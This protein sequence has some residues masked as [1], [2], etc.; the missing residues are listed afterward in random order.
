[1]DME[2]EQI[3]EK[4]ALRNV[5]LVTSR[6]LEEADKGLATA[7]TNRSRIEYYFTAKASLVLHVLD[8]SPEANRVTYLDA[9]LFFFADPGLL[10]AELAG[11]SVAIS[12]HRF[13]TKNQHLEE[14]GL[15]NAGWLM[16]RRDQDGMA[17]L[18]WWR[19]KCL[20]WCRDVVDGDRYADQKYIDRFSSMFRNVCA[21]KHAGANLAPW[22]L[23][24]AALE[25][26]GNM[27]QANGQ[28]LVFFHFHG[29]KRIVPGIFDAGTRRYGAKLSR[30]ARF[31]VYRSYLRSVNQ[32]ERLVGTG[33]NPGM[34]AGIRNEPSG[35]AGKFTSRLHAMGRR[36]WNLGRVLIDGSCIVSR[37]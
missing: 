32:C 22:N 16:F 8:R 26:S 24:T 23:D 20:E 11:C 5:R 15:Y 21:V 2:T 35:K 19:E 30:V 27:V 7:K 17:C 28:P 37:G 1:M 34:V 18:K 4:A 13:S 33:L 12:P 36:I 14:H 25:Y 9:D 3:L 6:Q 29:F 31:H 10:D